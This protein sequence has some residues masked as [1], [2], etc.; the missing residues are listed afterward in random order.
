MAEY[1]FYTAG[2]PELTVT[3]FGTVVC[4]SVTGLHGFVSADG[5]FTVRPSYRKLE[6]YNG[7]L[8]VDDRL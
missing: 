5:K 3:P 7:Y 1:Y 4:D 6:V 8:L 2:M